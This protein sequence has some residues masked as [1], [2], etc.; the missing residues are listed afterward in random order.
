MVLP[1]GYWIC[2]NHSFF[3]GYIRHG[4]KC[5]LCDGSERMSKKMM[6]NAE[7]NLIDDVTLGRPMSELLLT[8]EEN[9]VLLTLTDA[10][11]KFV[12]LPELHPVDNHE[13]M[14]AIH[15]AQTI[16]VARLYLRSLP[17]NSHSQPAADASR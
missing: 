12:A 6:P 9:E 3:S 1:E 8:P 16:I 4:L 15:A 17:S 2:N 7:S 11:N 14:H 13:F 5:L 10:W